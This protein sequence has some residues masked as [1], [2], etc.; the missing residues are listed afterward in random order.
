M[1]VASK[2][3]GPT[4]AFAVLVVVSACGGP[5]GSGPDATVD[6]LVP[7]SADVTVSDQAPL[8]VEVDDDLV[9]IIPDVDGDGMADRVISSRFENGE[10][11][12]DVVVGWPERIRTPLPFRRD[13]RTLHAVVNDLNHD[14]VPDLALSTTYGHRVE[15][16][17]GPFDGVPKSIDD[18]FWV[19]RTRRGGENDL[20]GQG[21]LAEDVTDDGVADLV[22]AA[23]GEGEEACTFARP[24]LV[25]F[26]PLAAGQA[27]SHDGGRTEPDD[28]RGRRADAILTK[29]S[30]GPASYCLGEHVELREPTGQR[31]LLLFDGASSLPRQPAGYP[32][33][34]RATSMA[35][36]FAETESF[37][38]TDVEFDV[39]GDRV[40]EPLDVLPSREQGWVRSSDGAVLTVVP[41]PGAHSI[42]PIDVNG[43]GY[44]A[45]LLIADVG[46]AGEFVYEVLAARA[47]WTAVGELRLSGLPA[48]LSWRRDARADAMVL[49]RGDLDGDGRLE[50]AIGNAIVYATA[51]R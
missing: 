9:L 50:T 40:P 8:M 32:L 48:P 44:G 51:D 13:D 2:M 34:I 12:T 41:E 26:G 24:T 25:F 21:L 18:G 23:P 6:G 16:A 45:P 10:G 49:T 7:D 30:D 36:P 42:V 14:G 31:L 28:D 47:P 3:H 35:L 19:A 29:P 27:S 5:A 17:F 11:T 4:P 33:P 39:D 46:E 1:I 37:A 20:L 22:I 15:V 38:M 43:D